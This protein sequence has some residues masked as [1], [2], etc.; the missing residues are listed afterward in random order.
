MMENVKKNGVENRTGQRTGICIIIGAG[1]LTVDAIPVRPEDFVI[2]ADGGYAHC[3]QLG[4]E[5]DL[6]LGDFDSLDE[7]NRR[8]V[9]ALRRE[10]PDRV[11]IFPVIKDDTDML[12]AMKEGLKR[13]F[14]S[15]DLYAAAQGKRLSHTI[16]N[17]QCLNYL[18]GHGASGRLMEAEETVFLLRNE[19]VTFEEKERGFLSLFSLGDRAEGVTIRNMKYLLDEA[20]VTNAFPV[21]VSN[22]FIG[23][24]GSVTV[25]NGT[26]LVILERR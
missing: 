5:P 25:K 9:E 14:V 2:A 10:Q 18:K 6:I 17:I 13:G 8:L 23:K 22:E 15:F 1:E 21:G 4:V 16:A 3:R 24:A 20:V 19:T 12:A 7:E 11:Q 26:L